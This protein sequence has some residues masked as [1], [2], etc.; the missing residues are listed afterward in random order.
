MTDLTAAQQLATVDPSALSITRAIRP[1]GTL[2]NMPCTLLNAGLIREVQASKLRPEPFTSRDIVGTGRIFNVIEQSKGYDS[3]IVMDASVPLTTSLMPG[4]SPVPRGVVLANLDISNA[5]A[6]GGES[7]VFTP[8]IEG[9]AVDVIDKRSGRGIHQE[10]VEVSTLAAFGV[11]RCSRPGRNPR[12][13]GNP[14]CI[15]W[16]DLGE[17]SLAQWKKN[18]SGDTLRGHFLN[19]LHRFGIAVPLG[20]SAPQGFSLPQLYQFGGTN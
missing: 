20:V 6:R 13:W 3:P 19:L 18:K 1:C 12:V 14:L 8:A 15:A 2:D 4:D 5:L 11:P 16:A 17:H 9:V 7:Q 10:S